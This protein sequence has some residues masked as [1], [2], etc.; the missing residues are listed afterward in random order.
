MLAG[1]CL[2][3]PVQLG[4]QKKEFPVKLTDPVTAILY[5]TADRQHMEDLRHAIH[6][7]EVVDAPPLETNVI[8]LHRH[9]SHLG[10]LPTLFWIAIS[11]LIVIFH[12]FLF[13]LI[14]NEYCSPSPDK[15]RTRY[16][17]L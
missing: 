12:L 11:I 8:A 2:D 4:P 9:G 1:G 3:S 17:K 14:Y 6:V 5:I 10:G 16:G 15:Y 7:K 13:K